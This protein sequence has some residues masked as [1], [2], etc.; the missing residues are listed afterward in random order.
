M[1]NNQTKVNKPLD[2]EC[3]KH[4]DTMIS[5]FENAIQQY[6]QKKSE[7]MKSSEEEK[8]NLIDENSKV[9]NNPLLFFQDM[10]DIA[11]KCKNEFVENAAEKLEIDTVKSKK[12]LEKTYERLCEFTNGNI[13][14]NAVFN[15][16]K[17][18]A[19]L[20]SKD[21]PIVEFLKSFLEK[22]TLGLYQSANVSAHKI[23]SFA[24]KLTQQQTNSKQT[25][26]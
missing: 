10:G 20:E 7:Y 14:E 22:I 8:R 26:F 9:Y 19:A 25:L 1:Q 12:D 3:Q 23:N 17:F 13:F 5:E 16:K 4:L 21:H 18:N 2:T 11:K 15:R 6:N 24:E